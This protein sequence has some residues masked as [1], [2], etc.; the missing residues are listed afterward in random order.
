MPSVFYPHHKPGTAER[1]LRWLAA[2]VIVPALVLLVMAFG[3]G[4]EL[5]D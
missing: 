3:T 2:W 4:D 1:A 5:E